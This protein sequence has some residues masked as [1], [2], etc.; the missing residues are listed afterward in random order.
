MY[1]RMYIYT[2]ARTHAHTR[3]H[4]HTRTQNLATQEL[5]TKRL[6]DAHTE[7]AQEKAVRIP[8]DP[9]K[10]YARE[11][12]LRVI[13]EL[14]DATAQL[15]HWKGM[16]SRLEEVWMYV[17]VCMCVCVCICVCV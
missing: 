8:P 2:H 1:T 12:H 14:E 13:E 3:T 4:T 16:V 17:C 11:D 9:G 10:M 7:L 5:L 6:T 15:Q